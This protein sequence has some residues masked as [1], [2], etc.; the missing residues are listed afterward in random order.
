MPG[1]M[2]KV[3]GYS[4]QALGG[5]T[6]AHTMGK[7]ILGNAG[8]GAVYG[9]LAGGTYGAFSDNTSVLGGALGGAVA[10]ATMGRYGVHGIQTFRGLD[11]ALFST[12]DRAKLAGMS[13]GSLMASD[14]M[15]AW[16]R[17][18]SLVS[19]HVGN[20]IKGIHK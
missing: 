2:S 13:T 9:G 11:P 20:V 10:G 8:L 3:L 17:G 6:S 12:V 1:L 5:I 15:R 4:G 19:N 14:A 16:G 7:T 18:S